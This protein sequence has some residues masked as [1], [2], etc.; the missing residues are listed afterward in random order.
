MILAVLKYNVDYLRTQVKQRRNMV[1]RFN[2]RE[3]HV[4]Q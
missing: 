4:M 1:E 3:W 2:V